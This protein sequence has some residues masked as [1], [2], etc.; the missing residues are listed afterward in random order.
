MDKV[1]ARIVCK[2]K[3]MKEYNE[4]CLYNVD[5]VNF[6]LQLSYNFNLFCLSSFSVFYDIATLKEDSTIDVHVYRQKQI[7]QIQIVLELWPIV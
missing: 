5:L 2:Y 1:E 3:D 6:L 7:V 4:W